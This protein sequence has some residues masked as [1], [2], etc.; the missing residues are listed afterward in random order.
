MHQPYACRLRVTGMENAQWLLEKLSRSF[1]FST[2]ESIQQLSND[3]IFFVSYGSHITQR[4]LENLITAIPGVRLQV[5]KRPDE[6]AATDDY[7]IG[8]TY[9]A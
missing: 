5:E 9:R 8:G 7:P 3:C 4:K 2:S 1:V 6:A